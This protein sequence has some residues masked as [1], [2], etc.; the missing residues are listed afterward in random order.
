M[1]STRH[2]YRARWVFPSVGEP[3]ENGFLEVEDGTVTGYSPTAP[4]RFTDL[5]NTAII[6]GLVNAHTHLEFSHL[7]AP[8][9]TA[10]SFAGWIESVITERSGRTVTASEARDMGLAEVR[11]T[12]TVGVGEILTAPWPTPHA[13]M[14]APA[15]TLFREVLGLNP[16]AID[17]RIAELKQ[18]LAEREGDSPNVRRGLSPHAPYSVHPDLFDR[19]IDLANLSSVPVAMHLAETREELELLSSGTGPLVD[20]F[21]RMGLWRPEVIPAGTRIL[22]YLRRMAGARQSL[23]IHGNYLDDDD[24][25]FLADAPHMTVVYCPQT[26]AHFGHPPHPLPKLLAKG[27]RVALGTDSRASSPTLDLWR[28]VLLVRQAFLQLHPRRLL[29]IATRNGAEALDAPTLGQLI[30]GARTAE[31]ALVELGEGSDSDPWPSLFAAGTRARPF[32]KPQLN[33]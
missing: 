29:D 22:D 27:I 12:G 24:I 32:P 20:L 23:V 28:D 33:L 9:P 16:A 15:V 10:E 21:A 3:I 18:H 26:H 19:V 1:A 13:H 7:A 5:G 11:Q 8:L 25:A 2:F 31:L 17:T 6:P 14:D 30:S 4:S